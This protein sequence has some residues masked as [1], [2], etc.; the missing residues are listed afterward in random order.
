MPLP[1][2]SIIARE[3]RLGNVVPFLGSGASVCGRPPKS[4]FEI[5]GNF[6]PLGRELAETLA[7]QIGFPDAEVKTNLPLVASYFQYVA[8]DRDNLRSSLRQIFAAPCEPGDVHQLLARVEAPLLIMT[9]N[10]DDLLERAFGERP[11]YLVIDKGRSAGALEVRRPDGAF[12]PVDARRLREE[13]QPEDRPIIYKM[14]GSF[15]RIS[16]DGDDYL[17][18]EEDYV[19]FLGRGDRAVPS[20]LQTRMRDRNF[21][22]LGYNLTD[23]NI[24]VL[25][26]RLRVQKGRVGPQDRERR[27]YWAVLRTPSQVEDDIWRAHNVSIYDQDLSEFVERLIEHLDD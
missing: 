3:L 16:P 9:T 20:Y 7:E 26:H 17:I 15:C 27:R 4:R 2:Y 13:L 8:A 10:Y 1:P 14:H 12:V 11:F 6:L 24:R 22:F 18:T 25:L 19:D 21:L 23:W 5:G